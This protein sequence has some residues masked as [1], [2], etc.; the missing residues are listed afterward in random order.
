MDCKL[1]YHA[2]GNSQGKHAKAVKRMM[3]RITAGTFTALCSFGAEAG[4]SFWDVSVPRGR[5]AAGHR[6]LT[7]GFFNERAFSMNI[8]H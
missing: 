4:C 2:Q 6:H 8:G 1:Q 5:A 7:Q 3:A